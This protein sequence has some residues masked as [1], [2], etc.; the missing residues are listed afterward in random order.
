MKPHVLRVAMILSLIILACLGAGYFVRSGPRVI[1]GRTA[2]SRGVELAVDHGRV[3]LWYREVAQP[4][5]LDLGW[6]GDLFRV[7]MPDL[8]RSLWEFD[9]HW[10]YPPSGAGGG[11]L[12]LLACPI[13]LAALPCLIAPIVWW[14]K[15]RMRKLV[16]FPVERAETATMSPTVGGESN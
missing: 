4:G 9:A 14:R 11:R 10:L 7:G 1:W 3:T 13:W 8:R 2:Q 16:G 12:F 15:R 5:P 6:T